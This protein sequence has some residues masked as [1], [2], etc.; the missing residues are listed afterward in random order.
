M[1]KSSPSKASSPHS[2]ANAG[3]SLF[4]GLAY[5]GYSEIPVLHD[6][7]IQIGH[8]VGHGFVFGMAGYLFLPAILGY[9]CGYEVGIWLQTHE[10]RCA[11]K[12]ADDLAARVEGRKPGNTR[13]SAGATGENF[14]AAFAEPE[15]TPWSSEILSLF[16]TY[17]PI[18]LLAVVVAK[19]LQH[20]LF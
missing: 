12:Q 5:W 9:L 4:V 16:I 17:I 2:C 13:A 3:L 15:L 7:P 18:F 10:A 6:L 8:F 19:I 14:E 11:K 1:Q 20:F